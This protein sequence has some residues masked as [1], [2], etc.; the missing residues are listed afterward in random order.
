MKFV[1]C[2]YVCTNNHFLDRKYFP[3][4]AVYL[5]K[6][7]CPFQFPQ[8]VNLCIPSAR[9][10]YPKLY[11]WKVCSQKNPTRYHFSIFLTRLVFFFELQKNCTWL[12]CSFLKIF[13]GT[14][15]FPIK[16]KTGVLTL[17]SNYQV[18]GE[19]FQNRT[20]KLCAHFFVIP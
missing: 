18:I 9:K 10:W 13:P 11:I 14:R 12:I 2:T 6:N 16:F 19:K 15:D 3:T 4:L 1:I 20:N 8:K 7:Y 17:Q 5:S